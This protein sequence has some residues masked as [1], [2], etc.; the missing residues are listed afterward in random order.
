M[1]HLA[2]IQLVAEAF[3]PGVKQA[4]RKANYSSLS[5]VEVK[6]GGSILPQ[7]LCLHGLVL[8]WLSAGTTLTY[9]SI[10]I[11]KTIHGKAIP[12]W[13]I[14]LDFVYKGPLCSETLSLSVPTKLT[15]TYFTKVRGKLTEVV[16]YLLKCG[17][18]HLWIFMFKLLWQ[19][20]YL[21]LPTLLMKSRDSVCLFF[22]G[23]ILYSCRATKVCAVSAYSGGF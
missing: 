17:A 16:T 18:K 2:P 6:N 10:Y 23:E 3:S 15:W 13:S 22:A 1:D 7:S 12:Y 20:L 19:V 5:I 9:L 14:R 11:H 4:G 21:T 8:N